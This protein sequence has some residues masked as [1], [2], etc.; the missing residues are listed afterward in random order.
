MRIFFS[1]S[2][3]YKP[4][5]R[6]IRRYLPEHINSWIDE[7]KLLIGDDLNSSLRE[8]IELDSDF[9]ILLID[10]RAKD[11]LWVQREVEWALAA[12]RRL[13]R[14]FLLPVVLDTDAWEKFEPA[15]LAKR[16]YLGCADFTEDGIRHLADGLSSQLFSWLSRDADRA[17]EAITGREDR[18]DPLGEADKFLRSVAGEI[19]TIVHPHRQRNPMPIESLYQRLHTLD[20]VSELNID[21][22]V[23]LVTRLQQQSLLAGLSFDGDE[24]F[25]EE[26]YYSWKAEAFTD[27]KRRIARYAARSIKSGFVVA[28]DAGSTTDEIARQIAR[29]VQL[30]RLNR[31]RIVTN[32]LTAASTL[33]EAATTLGLDDENDVLQV[34]I[35]GGRVRPNTLAVVGVHKGSATQLA[36]ELEFLGG[37]DICF[38]GTNGVSAAG[39]TTQTEMEA[40]TKTALISSSRRKVIATDPS[41]FGLEQERI[42]ATLD[43]EI[44]LITVRDGFENVVD[45]FA[46]ILTGRAV[47]LVCV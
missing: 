23:S 18:A 29:A 38:V 44:E 32:G 25:V 16:K 21:Q 11:S 8:A 14:T 31:L 2:S 42:F 33:L 35:S 28:L 10:Q 13:G 36:S 47:S 41:K 4:L 17:R 26:E 27:A 6:E 34:Y 5:L 40:M 15:E 20:A 1:H 22:F 9:V 37:A 46:A 19:R 7:E 3:H 39:F 12:E 30:R 45:D 24:I 43:E